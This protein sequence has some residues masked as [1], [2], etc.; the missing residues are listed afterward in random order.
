M[1]KRGRGERG[2]GKEWDRVLILSL[3]D[4]QCTVQP[5]EGLCSSNTALSSYQFTFSNPTYYCQGIFYIKMLF[6]LFLKIYG[7]KLIII[8]ETVQYESKNVQGQA[9]TIVH[10]MS[11]AGITL[12]QDC[13]NELVQVSKKIN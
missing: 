6:I 9:D 5:D 4:A 1:K 11:S 2:G 3:D 12:S 10:D 13:K 8:N 7:E